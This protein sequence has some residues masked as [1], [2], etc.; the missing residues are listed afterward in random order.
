MDNTVW[1]LY[2]RPHPHLCR[3]VGGPLRGYEGSPGFSWKRRL[4]LNDPAHL[5]GMTFTFDSFDCGINQGTF[6][7]SFYHFWIITLNFLTHHPTNQES[8]FKFL[9]APGAVLVF[10]KTPLC[11]ETG[12]MQSCIDPARPE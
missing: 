5:A 8:I 10:L 3:G 11:F 12:Q 9:G 7:R 1:V 6:H 4:V 2:L